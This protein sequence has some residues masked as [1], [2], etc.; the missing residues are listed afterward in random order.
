MTTAMPPPAYP[1]PTLPHLAIGSVTLADLATQLRDMLADEDWRP[2]CQ[3]FD[4]LVALQARLQ[5]N[6]DAC[7]EAPP[8]GL[9]ALISAY[10]DFCRFRRDASAELNVPD[11]ERLHVSPEEWLQQRLHHYRSDTAMARPFADYRVHR[12]PFR[13]V[14]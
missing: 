10:A 1:A 12:Q 3:D 7:A 5:A 14:G 6:P 9:I 13:V 11:G 4:S 2:A 8:P